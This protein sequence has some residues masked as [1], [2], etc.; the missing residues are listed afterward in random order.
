MTYERKSKKFLLIAT[1]LTVISLVSVGVTFAAISATFH[2]QAVTV[3]DVVQGTVK[4]SID[5]TTW[6]TTIPAFD[7]GNGHWYSRFDVSST[8]YT[9]TATITFAL[10]KSTD[11]GS[12]YSTTV[13]TFQV[14][15]FALTGSSIIYA[16]N[17]GVSSGTYHDFSTD[18]S[19]GG[20]YRISV[21]VASG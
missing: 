3:N 10:E 19:V 7:Q 12:T 14:T 1:A 4:Y 13:T 20:M 5:E 9:G 21:T 8:T 16:T 11:G 17:N 2:G 6:G 15:G 18:I